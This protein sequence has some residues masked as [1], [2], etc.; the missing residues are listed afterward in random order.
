MKA[1]KNSE[2][3][4]LIFHKTCSI[5]LGYVNAVILD[6][7]TAILPCLAC[8]GVLIPSG[9]QAMGIS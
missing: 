2:V 1:V 6:Y 5:Y 4:I 9:I 3:I 8:K 7:D